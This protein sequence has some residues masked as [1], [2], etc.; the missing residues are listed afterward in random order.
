MTVR[1]S[2]VCGSRDNNFNV[3]RMV[4]A[5]AVLVSHAWPVT[6]GIGA[7]EP[8]DRWIGHSLGWVSVGIFF[9]ISGF[10]IARSYDN[11]P[12]VE[13]WA[14]A[15]IMRLFPGLL[16]VL[17]LTALFLGPAV[18]VLPL[19]AYAA[20]PETWSYVP[21]NMSLT[22]L[23]YALPGVFLEAPYPQTINGSLWTLQHE[24]MCY[25][26]VLVIGSLGLLPR[27]GLLMAG[28]AVYLAGYYWLAS[29]DPESVPRRLMALRDLSFPFAIGT[30]LYVWRD[31]ILLGWGISAGL[32]AVA[33]ALY[34]TPVFTEAFLVWLAYTVFVVGYLPG[35]RIRDYNR[36]GDYSY[37]MY[38]Y[39]FPIQQLMM[40]LSGNGQSP[41]ENIL[42]AF[43]LA[44][45]CAIL[46]WHLVERP[47]LDRRRQLADVM[48]RIGR[49][50][51]K[52][53]LPR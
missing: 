34:T 33:L 37:G 16:V 52:A 53:P 25:M 29:L 12:G 10:L 7:E 43:P 51:R 45:G 15:R 19:G 18:T 8:L 38:I 27:R 42:T 47:A 6:M 9:V 20:D 30:L 46:S 21:R 5:S 3:I 11:A 4:A 40:H 28:F 36:L 26:G 50:E 13:E 41:A 35:G 31:R 23:Q 1:L 24:V 48:G 44:L 39:A 22:F 14:A 32:G 2:D 49:R 17:T